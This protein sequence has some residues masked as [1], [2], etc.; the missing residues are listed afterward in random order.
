MNSVEKNENFQSFLIFCKMDLE[1]EHS[2]VLEEA[3][4]KL[5]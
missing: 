2:D 5:D 3:M 4:R 1:M